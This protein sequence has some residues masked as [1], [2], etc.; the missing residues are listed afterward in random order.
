MHYQH[1]RD[2]DAFTNS[3]VDVNKVM[4]LQHLEQSSWS[5]LSTDL[6]GIH[7]QI[8]LEGGG[9]I[10]EGQSRVD[11]YIIFLPLNHA[12]AH[13]ANGKAL[14]NNSFAILEP[15]C[16][17][18]VRCSTKHDWCS[19]FVPTHNLIGGC[20]FVEPSDSKKMTCRVTYPNFQ[21][22]QKFLNV[23][24]SIMNTATNCLEFESS[25]AATC[26]VEQMLKLAH[27]IIG[28]RQVDNP[29]HNQKGRPKL[30]REELIRRSMEL[31]EQHKGKPVLISELATKAEVSE[32]TLRTAFNEYFGLG[33]HHYL[34][35][36]QL[37]QVHRLLRTAEPEAVS[38]SDV[39]LQYGVWEFS[40]FA[41]RYRRLF[42]ELPS[43]TLRKKR[44]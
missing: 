4:M 29:N 25:P 38:V 12:S 24:H 40:R 34:Q 16:E 6:S 39:I 5:L 14:D 44:G 35:L 11:G 30:S 8:G 1:F 32:R 41:S 36:R 27:F 43:E 31:L 17:F 22:R 42:G 23:V 18:C 26:A 33:P 15:G 21:L 28:Q 3:V 20:T 2:F 19:V 10:T 13:V 7:V 37:H 9:N